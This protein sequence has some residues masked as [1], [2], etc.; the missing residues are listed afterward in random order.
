M[1]RAT[2]FGG[3]KYRSKF[4][5]TVAELLTLHGVPFEYEVDRIHY[6]SS[7]SKSTCLDCGSKNVAQQCYY[8]PDFKIGDNVY[9]EAKGR[10]S[11]SDRRKMKQITQQRPDVKIYMMFQYD[12]WTTNNKINRYSDVCKK[13]GLEYTVGLRVPLLCSS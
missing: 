12:N 5:A 13:I 9:I 8:V 7:I 2:S 4:E 3:V 6:D 10:W 1:A 11:P